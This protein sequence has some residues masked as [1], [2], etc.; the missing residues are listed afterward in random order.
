MLKQITKRKYEREYIGSI[1]WLSFINF[2]IWSLKSKFVNKKRIKEVPFVMC[3]GFGP[4]LDLYLLDSLYVV[5]PTTAWAKAN[6]KE[7][8]MDCLGWSMFK[9]RRLANLCAMEYVKI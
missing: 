3:S 9:Q 7:L 4:K 6:K 1:E 5:M 8:M 2:K